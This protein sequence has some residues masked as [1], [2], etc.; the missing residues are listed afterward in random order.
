MHNDRYTI[1]PTVQIRPNMMLVY[2]HVQWHQSRPRHAADRARTHDVPHA[3][4]PDDK[5]AGQSN[6]QDELFGGKQAYSGLLC[7]SSKK[8]LTKAINL[9]VAIALPKSV[10]NPSTGTPFTFKVNF[11]TLTLPGAQGAISDKHLKRYAL[12]NWLKGMRRKHGLKS[13]VW[14]AERQYNGNLHFHVTSDCWLPL[15]SV[16]D[17]WNRHLR[18]LGLIDS[19]RAKFGHDRP[20][21]T[22]IHSVQKITNIAAYMVKYMSKDAKEHLDDKNKQLIAAGKEAIRPEA[23]EFRKIESQ[24]EWTDAINGRV[25]DCSVNLKMKARC[26]TEI[27]S[28]TGDEIRTII[29]TFPDSVKQCD[30]CLLIF[31]PQ[32]TMEA[33]LSNYLV[34]LWRDYLQLIRSFEPSP[35]VRRS[36]GPPDVA[37]PV[38]NAT[39]YPDQLYFNM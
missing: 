18:K 25:W 29:A 38:S 1:I 16:R 2:N 10:I 35:R 19:F 8:R 23:H 30:K 4:A 24:P 21:S 31:L 15:D 37:I 5:C 17:E 20:N 9:L 11:I 6:H 26:E 34:S 33:V 14:R 13:Y 32:A 36:Q 3:S 12:D 22:D 27:D 28:S 7:P 39:K